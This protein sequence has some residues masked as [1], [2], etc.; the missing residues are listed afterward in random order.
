MV[1][2]NVLEVP[3]VPLFA[4]KAGIHEV[5]LT[6]V[7]HCINTWQESQRIFLWEKDKS[8]Y[9]RVL[10]ETEESAKKLKIR[11]KK[12]SI[13][14]VNVPIC[15]ENPLRNLYISVEGRVSPCVYLYPPLTSPFRRIFC[16]REYRVEKV[17]FGN[18]FREAF[19]DIW[20]QGEYE[21]FRDRFVERGKVFKESYF[22]LWD[23][24]TLLKSQDNVLQDPPGPCRTCH[25]ILGI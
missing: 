11:L 20:H 25:K 15:E 12:P 16:G 23:S 3:E 24:P 9:E 1:K 4:K 19:S 14:P 17:S 2:D 22:S 6:N 18:L 8:P 21:R 5:I 13:L 7:C 10:R